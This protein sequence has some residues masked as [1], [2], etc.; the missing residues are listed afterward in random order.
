MLTSVGAKAAAH[1]DAAG[2]LLA[3][4]SDSLWA[5]IQEQVRLTYADVC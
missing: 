5:V 2:P 4:S 1:A 3:L